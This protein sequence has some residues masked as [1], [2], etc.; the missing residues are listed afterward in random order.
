MTASKQPGLRD[1]AL[2]AGAVDYFEK[3]FKSLQ[4]IQP[5]HAM[6]GQQ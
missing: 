4:L 6:P 2:S 5:I 3:P 1:R